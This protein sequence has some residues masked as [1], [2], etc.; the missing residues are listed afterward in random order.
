MVLWAAGLFFSLSLEACLD[1]LVLFTFSQTGAFG[2]YLFLRALILILE[3]YSVVVL[4]NH[5]IFLF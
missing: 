5:K 2:R 4:H 3:G 1:Y